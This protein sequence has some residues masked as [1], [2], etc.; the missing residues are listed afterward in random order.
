MTV[1]RGVLT[2]K[3]IENRSVNEI[4]LMFDLKY[5]KKIYTEKHQSCYILPKKSICTLPVF[6]QQKAFQTTLLAYS[7]FGKQ[8]LIL[9]K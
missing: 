3:S 2:L 4:T 8:T 6:S 7:M 9:P 1:I 5:I